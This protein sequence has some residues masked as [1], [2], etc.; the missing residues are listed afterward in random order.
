MPLNSLDSPDAGTFLRFQSMASQTTGVS[1]VW[2]TI[3]SGRDKKTLKL[4]VTDLCERNSKVT[5]E[6]TAE[7]ASNAENVSNWWR[8][9]AA[10]SGVLGETHSSDIGVI[11]VQ[12]WCVNCWSTSVDIHNLALNWI[13]C[14]RFLKH[15][16]WLFSG[17]FEFDMHFWILKHFTF[18]LCAAWWRETHGRLI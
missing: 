12:L 1:N 15:L 11:A 2:S 8:H 17:Y 18:V 6:F 9:H 3:C 16:I 13:C 14:I 7:R 4:R 10:L 5:S